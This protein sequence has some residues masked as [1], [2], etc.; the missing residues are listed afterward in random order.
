[1]QAVHE[2]LAKRIVAC[3]A[4][5]GLLGALGSCGLN[6]ASPDLFVLTR[7]GHG[8]KLTLL[9]ND[10][11]TIRCNG[12]ASKPIPDS[13]LLSARSLVTQL[14][15]DAQRNLTIAAAPGSEYSFNVKLSV[16]TI[17]F[18]DTA[19]GRRTELAQAELFALQA[20]HG[21]CGLRSA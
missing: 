2:K 14:T 13:M 4:G 7:T 19:A 18:G 6:V 20:A 21:P 5:C 8:A 9:V 1:M 3:A 12:G 15:P 17:S 11:G 16:G 10:G